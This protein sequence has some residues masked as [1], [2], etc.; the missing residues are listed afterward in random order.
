MEASVSADRLDISNHI[1]E[2]AISNRSTADYMHVNWIDHDPTNEPLL[3]TSR[4]FCETY[5]IDPHTQ[6]IVGR[7][8][9]PFATKT[10]PEPKWMNDG[11]TQLWGPHRTN[12]VTSSESAGRMQG[13]DNGWMR[14]E[15]RR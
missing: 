7:W 11:A 3:L 14:P 12:F 10:G 13:F 2:R 9:N 8:G 5:L 4:S 1:P 6:Q 15:D